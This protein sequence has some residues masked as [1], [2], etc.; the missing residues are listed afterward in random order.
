MYACAWPFTDLQQTSTSPSNPASH[1]YN[2]TGIYSHFPDLSLP[3][4]DKQGHIIRKKKRKGMHVPFS[5]SSPAHVCTHLPTSAFKW[6]LWI[7]IA[8]IGVESVPPINYYWWCRCIVRGRL[9]RGNFQG[10]RASAGSFDSSLNLKKTPEGANSTLIYQ[11]VSCL[12]VYDVIS[13]CLNQIEGNPKH[14][15]QCRERQ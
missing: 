7:F 2:T 1:L 6:Q 9:R 3:S 11:A 12:C 13:A 10:E 8:S 5:S 15:D 14:S 4:P